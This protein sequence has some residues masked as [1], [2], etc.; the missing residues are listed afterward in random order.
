MNTTS[1][2]AKTT[3]SLFVNLCLEVVYPCRCPTAEWGLRDKRGKAPRGGVPE[4]ER[5][6][7]ERDEPGNK[8]NS[9]CRVTLPS[10]HGV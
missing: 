2:L 5:G 6:D 8:K 7:T 9:S 10:L 4:E 1:Q 3:P